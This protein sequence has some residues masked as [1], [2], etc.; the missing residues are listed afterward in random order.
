MTVQGQRSTDLC[1]EA[2]HGSACAKTLH[3]RFAL[4]IIEGIVSCNDPLAAHGLDLSKFFR[5]RARSLLDDPQPPRI[6]ASSS[7]RLPTRAQGEDP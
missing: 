1:L 4:L 2:P 3:P 5:Y 6:C 7:Y